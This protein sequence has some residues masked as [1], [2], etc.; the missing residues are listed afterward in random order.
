MYV[1]KKHP[2]ISIQRL[3]GEYNLDKFKV[4]NNSY[5]QLIYF[6]NE[7]QY[8][9]QQITRQVKSGDLLTIPSGKLHKGKLFSQAE[10]WIVFFS[11]TAVN[12]Y[13]WDADSSL[14]WFKDPLIIPFVKFSETEAQ[15]HY[16]NI[17][18]S[19]RPLWC[20]CLKA[21]HSE[22]NNKQFGYK[23]VARAYLTEILVNLARIIQ[24]EKEDDLTRERH[25]ILSQVFQYIDSNY[26]KSISLKDIAQEVNFSPTYLASLLRQLVGNTAL[27][28][29]RERRMLEA[30]RLLL[31][32]ENDIGTIGELVGYKSTT[33]FIRQ[34][35]RVHDQTPYVWRNTRRQNT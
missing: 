18:P 25:P 11:T 20:Q 26:K 23:Q 2:E 15:T 4:S 22:L 29:I 5:L 13:Y 35:R 32:T 33:Y 12:P 30:R 21:L 27:E 7:G 16:Y 28:L 1:D 8:Q 19:Y 17:P 6:E 10:G 14:N 9:Q 24:E 31:N 3:D 34:F